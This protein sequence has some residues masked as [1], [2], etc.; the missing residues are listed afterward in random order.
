[1]SAKRRTKAPVAGPARD[2]VVHCLRQRLLGGSLPGDSPLP[3]VCA[4]ARR[5][6][7]SQTTVQ[8]AYR[9]LEAEGLVETRS[10]IGRFP[11]PLLLRQRRQKAIAALREAVRQPVADAMDAGLSRTSV[12]KELLRLL[13]PPA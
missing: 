1:M 4:L 3:T 7:V 8:E 5:K 13:G 9:Q 2:R 6:N 12:R 10:R 11:V